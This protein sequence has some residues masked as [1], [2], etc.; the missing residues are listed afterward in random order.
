VTVS[1]VVKKG[2]TGVMIALDGWDVGEA[3]YKATLKPGKHLIRWHKD[4][5]IDLSCDINVPNR[6]V[7]YNVDPGK[8]SCP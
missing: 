2:A 1:L 4:G 8:P 6:N 5:L 7:S 3:P